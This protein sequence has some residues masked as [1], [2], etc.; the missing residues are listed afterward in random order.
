[1]SQE[2]THN[3]KVKEKCFRQNLQLRQKK[4]LTCTGILCFIII[5][6][7]KS[8]TFYYRITIQQTH[9]KI[10]EV[11]EEFLLRTVSSDD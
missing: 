2:I 3:R 8:E 7:W 10:R 6:K 5:I 9:R 11:D 1:M 4:M